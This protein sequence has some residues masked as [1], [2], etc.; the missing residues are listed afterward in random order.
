MNKQ[1][2]KLKDLARDLE[3]VMFKV[4]NLEFFISTRKDE[5][6]IFDTIRLVKED[7]RKVISK[8]FKISK[9]DSIE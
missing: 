2:E 7:T 1:A 5:E 8:L 6:N 9:T 3:D 4:E